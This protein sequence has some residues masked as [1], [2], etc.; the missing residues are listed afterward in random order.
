[1]VREYSYAQLCRNRVF[2]RPRIGRWIR[3]IGLRFWSG[4]RNRRLFLPLTGYTAERGARRLV[5]GLGEQHLAVAAIAAP[6]TALAE[7]VIAGVLRTPGAN[8]RRIFTADSAGKWHGLLFL[9]SGFGGG[10]GQSPAAAL[11]FLI[12]HVQ[13]LFALGGQ[14]DDV[15]LQP[16][17]VGAGLG[18]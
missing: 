18:L 11:R 15:P 1:M 17:A 5:H 13:L 2:S 4:Y 9:L 6:Q 3:S 8:A 10:R 12:H 14:V 7:M 16:V